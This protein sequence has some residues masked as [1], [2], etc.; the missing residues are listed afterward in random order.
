MESVITWAMVCVWLVSF[1]VFSFGTFCV[2]HRQK[3]RK[4]PT[5]LPPISVIRPLKGLDPG[6]KNNLSALAEQDYPDYVVTLC[7]SDP[8]DEVIEPA[9]RVVAEYQK[10]PRVELLIGDRSEGANPKVNN[11]L[12]AYEFADH[13]LI[14][15][16]DSNVRPGPDYLKRMVAEFQPTTGV[17][18]S[19]VVGFGGKGLGGAIEE[20]HL[21]T[22]VHR[23]MNLANAFGRTFVLGKSMMFRKSVFERFG[24]LKALANFI[25]EDFMAGELVKQM[26]Y[27]VHLASQPVTQKVGKLK[28]AQFWHRHVR[29]SV[30]QKHSA[31]WVFAIE[32]FAFTPVINLIGALGLQSALS[33][34]LWVSM[35]ILPFFWYIQDA[36]LMR[37]NSLTPS[38]F[39][40]S[41][42]ET[43]MPFVWMKSLLSNTI[44]WRGNYIK[45]GKVNSVEEPR[46]NPV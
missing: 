35:P 43:L 39:V 4:E 34:P 27:K 24:G 8:E 10:N 6:L 18:T 46:A 17:L 33:V 14:L 2:L 42:K 36:W 23:W 29:W 3:R 44:L 20:T 28:V 31:P 16:S 13:D 30:L 40:W 15:I 12:F 32:P 45:V 21:S 5:G 26:G 1:V 11:M 19:S 41:V 38:F 22:F 7:V 9:K 25:A 37:S